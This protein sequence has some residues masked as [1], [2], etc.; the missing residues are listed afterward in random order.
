MSDGRWWIAMVTFER[1][2]ERHNAILPSWASG[3]C[4]WMMA[5]APDQD[6]ARQF[7]LSDVE[8]NDL[9]VID[10]ED[11]QE[12]FSEADLAGLDERLAANF[13]AIE[14]GKRTIWG[15]IHC[16]KGEGAA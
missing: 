6:R 11:E 10:M 7:L 13:R 14:L 9:V 16:Y 1:R 15:T 12:V 3:A 4:G 8:Q 2:C 5:L